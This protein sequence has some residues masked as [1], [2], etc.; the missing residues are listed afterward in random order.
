MHGGLIVGAAGSGSG[1]RARWEGAESGRALRRHRAE[2][3]PGA[4]HR[5]LGELLQRRRPSARR[6]ISPWKLYISPLHRA[7]PSCAT[8]STS[9]TTFPSTSRC[10][11]L[12]VFVLLVWWVRP[13]GR[14]AGRAR[15]SFAYIGPLLGGGASSSRRCDSTASGWARCGVPQLASVA[16]VLVRGRR[17]L[18]WVLR[19]RPGRAGAPVPESRG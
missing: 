10:G 13:P 3:D 16:G 4:G 6:P 9:T 14:P 19:G 5:P 11:N 15:S 18:L 8:S 17:G 1:S 7:G 12:L 2:H